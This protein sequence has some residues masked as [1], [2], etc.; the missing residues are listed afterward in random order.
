MA[1]TARNIDNKIIQYLSYLTAIQKEALLTVARSF[2][3]EEEKDNRML[4][5][6]QI[7]ELDSRWL[8]YKRGEG[9]NHTWSETKAGILKRVGTLKK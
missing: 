5:V 4:T 9:I 6:D 7:R 8:A 2:V 1:A 3:G